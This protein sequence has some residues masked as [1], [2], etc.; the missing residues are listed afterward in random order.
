MEFSPQLAATG[1]YACLNMLILFWISTVT[2]KLRGRYKVSIGDG[3]VAHLTRIMR[4]HANAVENMPM[5]FVLLVIGAL[6]GMPL[7]MVHVLGAMFT[8][9]RALHAWHFIQADAPGWQ[10]AGGYGLSALA[11]LLIVIGFLYH[12]V[13]RLLI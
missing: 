13:E 2:G 4:G 7:I 8:I 5:F 6:M 9:G 10:R 12:A 3:G 11:Q 1:I